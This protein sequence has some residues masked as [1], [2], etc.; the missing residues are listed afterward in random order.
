MLSGRSYDDNDNAENRFVPLEKFNVDGNMTYRFRVISAAMMFPFRV[1]VDQH[2]LTL[3]ATDGDR[4][5][6]QTAE[7]FIINTGER[8]DFYI[9]TDQ[10]P[11]NYWI[12]SDTIELYAEN[13]PVNRQHHTEA[14]LHY[15]G[16]PDAEPTSQRKT[17]TANDTCVVVNCPF[18][19]YGD[20]SMHIE[21]LPVSEL[22]SPDNQSVPLPESGDKWEEHF[23]NFHFAGSD[24][25]PG[26]R[27][28]VNGH[29]FVLPSSPPQN[30]HEMAAS[31]R[32]EWFQL[33]VIDGPSTMIVETPPYSLTTAPTH[34]S[35]DVHLFLIFTFGYAANGLEL[36]TICLHGLEIKD[37]KISPENGT[38]SSPPV[39]SP[40]KNTVPVKSCRSDM[41]SEY[42]GL[43]DLIEDVGPYEVIGPYG[44]IEEVAGSF[45]DEAEILNDFVLSP[46][47]DD[48]IDGLLDQVIND[49]A[50]LNCRIPARLYA[51]AVELL[52]E[53]AEIQRQQRAE[54]EQ[55]EMDASESQSLKRRRS[56]DSDTDDGEDADADITPPPAKRPRLA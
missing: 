11:G 30:R 5:L 7:S 12:R 48:N 31:D 40:L 2:E 25:N 51:F 19:Q 33:P 49:L 6:E 34:Q 1:S 23:I 44:D 42:V 14:I 39:A 56:D 16:A 17:C 10:T 22:R 28:S 29:R 52:E 13:M 24:K 3:I 26:Q 4:I 46:E 37:F 43:P 35:K 32:G 18:R 36:S 20:Q 27:P 47:P 50:R 15:E 53:E 45:V 54:L 38:A 21:C 9:T 41:S 55:V 8:Y